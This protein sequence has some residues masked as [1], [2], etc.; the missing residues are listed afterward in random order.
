M[1]IF[2]IF[3]TIFLKDNEVDNRLDRIDRKAKGVGGTFSE[4]GTTLARPFT[5]TVAP[6]RGLIGMLTNV[7]V[8]VGGIIAGAAATTGWNWLVKGNA[9]MEQYQQTLTVVMKDSKKAAE[10][11][12]WAK[13]FAAKTPFEIPGIVEATTRLSAYGLD[14]KKVLGT[15]GD[16]AAAMGKPLMQAVEAIADAQTG[17]LERLKEFGITKKMLIDQA[18]K[19]GK[20]EIVNAKGQ[21]TDMEGMNEALFALMKERYDGAMKAQS[22]TLNG[23]L[24]NMKDWIGEAGKTLGKPIFDKLKEA[25]PGVL[26]WMQKFKESGKLEQW[27][28]SFSNGIDV[29]IDVLGGLFGIVKDVASFIIDNWGAIEPILAGVLAGFM[30]FKT[31]AWLKEVIAGI[32][33]AMALLN[34]TMLANPM[35]WVA[36]AIGVLV[37]AGIW[38][39]RNWDEVR[40]KLGATWDWLKAKSDDIWTSIKNFFASTWESIKQTT[41]TVWTAIV[42]IVMTIASPFIA[43]IT[44]LFNNMKNGLTLIMTGL[45]MYFAGVWMVIKNVFLGAVLL[46]V[47]LVTG[48][49]TDLKKNALAIWNNIKDGLGLIW[50]GIKTVFSGALEVVKGYLKGTW[51]NIKNSTSAI[52][53]GIKSFLVGLWESIKNAV[54]SKFDG[55]RSAVRDKMSAAKESIVSVWNSVKSFFTSIDLSEIGRDIIEGLIK[56]I[57][58]KITAV[59]NAIK[60]VTGAITGKI[61]NILGINS[62]SKV[63]MEF[64]LNIGQGLAGGI[65]GSEDLVTK[66]S[67]EMAM[68]SIPDLIGGGGTTTTNTK[69][70]NPQITNYYTERPYSP[71]EENRKQQQMLRKLAMGW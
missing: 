26:D 44:N 59:S 48:N 71:A 25:L 65:T 51:E 9:E 17:E 10:T 67:S 64:G 12:D 20:G 56:G 55:L 45:K 22:G 58:D 2:R 32:R 61:K 30:A 34:F 69:T 41:L 13:K 60:E 68:K 4:L 40:A 3:G 5:A 35:V 29:A 43:G 18:A 46:L 47:N 1:E 19:M 37:A 27:A 53:N 50:T 24:S 7:N 21:I 23:M 57:R 11:L 63:F 70:F 14:A 16:M 66:A 33:K 28:N 8:L 38:L 36:I 54:K 62:P 31:I 52:W 6:I 49:F 42:S 39:W 15:T